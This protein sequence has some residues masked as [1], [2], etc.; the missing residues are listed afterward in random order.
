M[1]EGVNAFTHR[2]RF[3]HSRGLGGAPA[4]M[5]VRKMGKLLRAFTR[6]AAEEKEEE[7]AKNF[8]PFSLPSLTQTPLFVERDSPPRFQGR[9]TEVWSTG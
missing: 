9:E 7:A 5:C 1:S 4:K 6:A 8:S 3:L 2:R